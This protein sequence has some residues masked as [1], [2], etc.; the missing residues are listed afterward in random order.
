MAALTLAVA[1]HPLLDATCFTTALPRPLGELPSPAS[2]LALLCLPG[3]DAGAP[4]AATD[5]DRDAVR[6]LL[7]HGGFRPSGRSKPAS[8]YLLKALERGWLGPEAGINLAVDAC[9]AVSLHSGLPISVLDADRLDGPLAIRLGE[10]GERYVFNPS[11]Q[12][13]ALAGLLV[14]CDAQGPCGSPVKDSQRTKTHAETRATLTVIWGTSELP[15][16]AAEAA[17]WHRDLLRSLGVVTAE[18]TPSP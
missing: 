12:E 5:Q 14:L 9:N 4:L 2:L 13:L 18:L 17:M 11:G 15:G 6:A 1:P 16:R 3:P 10:P 8:E 7:R